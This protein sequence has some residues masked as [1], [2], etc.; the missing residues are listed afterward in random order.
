MH[1]ITAAVERHVA[2]TSA[3]GHAAASDAPAAAVATL[4]G[5]PPEGPFCQGVLDLDITPPHNG[6]PRQ[7]VSRSGNGKISPLPA[8]DAHVSD[9]FPSR[10]QQHQP[11]PPRRSTIS[12]VYSPHAIHVGRRQLLFCGGGADGAESGEGYE[13]QLLG[14]ETG[15][16]GPVETP[17]DRT[18]VFNQGAEST[19][20]WDCFGTE[21][22]RI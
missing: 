9:T 17:A 3:E 12:T 10:S 13:G 16:A 14:S 8:T 6:D 21:R 5:G 19:G 1:K 2:D 4:G 11:A 20:Q 7:Q 18:A 15:P 22:V